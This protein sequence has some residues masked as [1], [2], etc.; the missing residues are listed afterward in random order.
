MTYRLLTYRLV[1]DQA[2]GDRLGRRT[3]FASGQMLDGA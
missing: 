1:T 3:A 2:V